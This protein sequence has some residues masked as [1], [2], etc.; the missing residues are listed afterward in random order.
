MSKLRFSIPAMAVA[1]A[2][3]AGA[4]HAKAAAIFGSAVFFTAR[5]CTTLTATQICGNRRQPLVYSEYAGGPGQAVNYFDSSPAGD[6]M[7]SSIS[8]GAGA[9]P[10]IR[11]AD[12]AVSNYRVNVNAFAYN[13]FT[14]TSDAATELSYAGDLHIVNSSGNPLGGNPEFAGGS[15]YFSWVAIW[16]PALV[17]GII[18]PADV[19]DNAFGNYDCSTP[20]VLGFGYSNGPLAG[21]EQS[22]HM[23]TASCSDA[24]VMINPG[25]QILAVA[26]L[27]TPVN[28]GG[29]V[30][31]SHTFTMNYDP[32][33]SP[34]VRQNLIQI[35]APAA[36][37][38]LGAVPE[39]ASWALLLIGFGGI[40]AM[41][42]SRRKIAAIAC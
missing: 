2:L 34:D 26:F 10:T 24:P 29:F 37:E 5:D 35:M 1:A 9:L 14:N 13:A 22:I 27:Q 41:L 11:Q 20:G 4:P 39:P 28:R 38:G 42:R 31:A 15:S 32:D 19:F 8:F 23:S 7:S 40:G 12:A 25:Q 6:F 36:P 3:V 30:D 33:L 21:G 18:G 16:D 17:A